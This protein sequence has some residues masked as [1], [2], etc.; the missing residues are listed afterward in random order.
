[1]YLAAG[2]LRR[3]YNHMLD[4][5][6]F[7]NKDLVNELNLSSVPEEI[8]S[9]EEA[10]RALKDLPALMQAALAEISDMPPA[11]RDRLV[12]EWCERLAAAYLQMRLSRDSAPALEAYLTFRAQEMAPG[13]RP[14]IYSAWGWW[15]Y[16][17]DLAKSIITALEEME[18]NFAETYQTLRRD[19]DAKSTP[20]LYWALTFILNYNPPLEY[21]EMFNIFSPDSLRMIL[22]W[23]RSDFQDFYQAVAATLLEEAQRQIRSA[24][25]EVAIAPPEISLQALPEWSPARLAEEVKGNLSEIVSIQSL[26]LTA[27]AAEVY[28]TDDK[29]RTF[30]GY[31]LILSPTAEVGKKIIG[32]LTEWETEFDSQRVGD[33]LAFITV[34]D[35]LGYRRMC[36]SVGTYIEIAFAGLLRSYLIQPQDDQSRLDFLNDLRESGLLQGIPLLSNAIEWVHEVAASPDGRMRNWEVVEQFLRDCFNRQREQPIEGPKVRQAVMEWIEKAK[37]ILNEYGNLE[38][39]PKDADEARKFEEDVREFAVETERML[40]MLHGGGGLLVVLTPSGTY[41]DLFN[42]LRVRAGLT[43]V[44]AASGYYRYEGDKKL[45]LKWLILRGAVA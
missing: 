23:A 35:K 1:M 11:R 39:P 26:G 8:S 33:S 40:S 42:L 14:S 30:L 45:L 27:G 4:W 5:L 32:I 44:R 3:I 31:Y 29:E 37:E 43:S 2:F 13:S 41:T 28:I 25:A 17:R 16:L 18:R 24:I 6:A 10:E 36:S 20:L 34:T 7:Y 38:R 9:W 15:R 22:R 19:A 21:E 12:V